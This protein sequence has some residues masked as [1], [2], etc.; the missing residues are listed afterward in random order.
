MFHVRVVA[1]LGLCALA[2]NPARAAHAQAVQLLTDR[3][4]YE[5]GDTVVVSLRNT[6]DS[7]ITYN[8]CPWMLELRTESTWRIVTQ[9]PPPGTDC[10]AVARVLGAHQ[11]IRIHIQIP[12]ESPS[13]DYRVRFPW[14]G[15]RTTG[16][17]AVRGQTH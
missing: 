2:A 6:G 5:S 11:L 14:I 12:I 9:S 10:V 15:D 16:T 3:P 1:T 8:A 17:F 7:T 13:G 4:T